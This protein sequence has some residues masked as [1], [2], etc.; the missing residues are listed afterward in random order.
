[1]A[2]LLDAVLEDDLLTV[3]LHAPDPGRRVAGTGSQQVLA[4]VPGA[5]EDLRVVSFEHASLE[6]REC[7]LLNF[8]NGKLSG[9]SIEVSHH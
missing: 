4:R 6:I 1:L 8:F 9:T 7:R 3:G 5:D 2:A